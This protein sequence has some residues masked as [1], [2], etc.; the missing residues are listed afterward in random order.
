MK[1]WN[2]KAEEVKRDWWVVDASGLTLGRLATKVA[3]VLRGKNKAIFTPH[4]DTGDFVVVVNAEKIEMS[5]SKWQD[6]NY[7]RHSRFFGSLKTVGAEEMRSKKP[8]FIIEDA[9]WGM[10]PKN[11]LSRKVIK[12]LKIYRG[13]GHPHEAQKPQAMSVS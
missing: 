6:K 7:Y 9:V 4:V 10:L 2:A 12:K 5:G 1:T 11:K 8:E 3:T 13:A